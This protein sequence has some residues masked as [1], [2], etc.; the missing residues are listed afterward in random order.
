MLCLFN[1]TD[2]PQTVTVLL[3]HPGLDSAGLYTLAL[4][5][6]V[7]ATDRGAIVRLA[8]PS[9]ATLWA[10]RCGEELTTR[11]DSGFVF[12][13]VRDAATGT[14]L[15]GAAVLLGWLRITQTGPT[16]VATQEE[17]LTARTDSTGT[18]YACGV[19]RD[20]NLT[21]RGYADHDSTGMVELQLGSRGVGRQDLSIARAPARQPAVL[22]GTAQT[23][24]HAP[25]AG[26]RVSVREGPSSKVDADGAF[27]LRGVA[28]GTQW[29][30]VQAIGRTPFGEAVDIQPDETTRLDAALGPLAVLLEPVR[31]VG[32]PAPMLREF[33]ER[34]R[35]GLGYHL[36]EDEIPRTGTLRGA[37]GILPAIRFDRGQALNDFVAKL[38][39]SNGYC[40][41]ALYVDGF[42]SDYGQLQGY[43]PADIVGIELYPRQSIVPI[44]FQ[45]FS[46][47]G[48]PPCGVLLIW[49]KY[50][51]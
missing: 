16:R 10:R 50:L 14:H 51:K 8:T 29:V 18:Y 17:S 32:Q 15:H 38:P 44:Q 24:E 34:R 1:W 31:V 12:G 7:R 36:T 42:R 22:R 9:L 41:A 25:L 46:E 28:P 49:T 21:L 47:G 43:G 33:E 5:L 2:Q 20:M 37:L 26:G 39:S 11:V 40:V 4:P 35:T 23:T 6:T 19:S 30:M 3:S 48:Q 27:I 13:V 45:T